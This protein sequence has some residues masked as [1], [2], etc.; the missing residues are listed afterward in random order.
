MITLVVFIVLTGAQANN[1]SP[2]TIAII[3]AICIA[4]D[5]NAILNW[6]LKK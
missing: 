4:S 5:V 2:D 6:I 1:L 3:N